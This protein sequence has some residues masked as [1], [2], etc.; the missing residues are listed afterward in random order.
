M[1]DMSYTDTR[2]DA[3]RELALRLDPAREERSRNDFA[4]AFQLYGTNERI[5]PILTPPPR[6]CLEASMV[7]RRC[8]AP[9]CRRVQ[10][11]PSYYPLTSQSLELDEVNI[12]VEDCVQAMKVCSHCKRRHYCSRECQVAN[13]NVHKNECQAL[14]GSKP[15]EP[16]C[17]IS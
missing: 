2:S 7:M 10:L 5:P 4:L 11:H 1:T 6:P 12:R 13:W 3:P 9:G 16:N 17:L 8:A 15:E 14:L